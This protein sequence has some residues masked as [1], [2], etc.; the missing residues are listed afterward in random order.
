MRPRVPVKVTQASWKLTCILVVVSLSACSQ[1]KE[2]AV[3]T[4]T[5]HETQSSPTAGQQFD[6]EQAR[7]YLQRH[8]DSISFLEGAL[9]AHVPDLDILDYYGF[10]VLPSTGLA[11]EVLYL[12][13]PNELLSSGRPDDFDQLMSQL[14]VGRDPSAIE[15]DRF[16]RL[17]LRF[18]AL[19]RGTVLKSIDD[20]IL[21]RPGQLPESRFAPPQVDL[22]PD[23]ARYSFWMFDTDRMQPFLWNVRVTPEGRT[24]FSY[25]Q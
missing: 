1:T 12:V 25:S 17:F 16:A 22:G 7:S 11:G 15:I 9:V 5:S 10:S 20:E 18:R 3:I 19:R 23:G 4:P 6:Q 24:E 2:F 21:L 13:G 8:I 14:G